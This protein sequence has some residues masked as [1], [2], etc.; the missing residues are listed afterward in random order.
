M[1]SS[2]PGGEIRLGER[3]LLFKLSHPRRTEV[4]LGA[5]TQVLFD[6]TTLL[7]LRAPSN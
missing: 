4:N 7:K 5:V 2:L 3:S 1:V 6:W